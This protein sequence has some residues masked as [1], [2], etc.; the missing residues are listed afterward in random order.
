MDPIYNGPYNKRRL[1]GNHTVTFA[2]Q[3]TRDDVLSKLKDLTPSTP[4]GAK[5]RL[6]KTKTQQQL[7]RNSALHLAKDLLSKD[8]NS[9][10]KTI[11][12]NWKL[13]GTSNRMV[14]ADTTT[15]FTQTRQDLT[16]TFH[17]PFTHLTV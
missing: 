6:D 17:A 10:G 4:D 3:D 14:T 16:G 7:T 2:T 9:Q 5:L 8:P 12:I 15:A 1:T 11:T 13:D